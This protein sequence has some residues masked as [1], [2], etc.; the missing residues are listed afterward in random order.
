MIF[1]KKA[2]ILFGLVYWYSTFEYHNLRILPSYSWL[3]TGFT[4]FFSLFLIN[5]LGEILPEQGKKTLY[6]I[7]GIVVGTIAREIALAYSRDLAAQLG[8]EDLVLG[9]GTTTIGPY[10]VDI[11]TVLGVFVS[12]IM[13]IVWL[14][15]FFRGRSRHRPGFR[16]YYNIK[17]DKDVRPV[18][19]F[20]FWPLVYVVGAQFL[21]TTEY[22][23][24]FLIFFPLPF[25]IRFDSIRVTRFDKLM[26]FILTTLMASQAL[27]IVY[28][29][30]YHNLYS[31]HQ[32]VLLNLLFLI[33]YAV[34]S[35][36]TII[37]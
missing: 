29:G 27:G 7:I 16:M 4:I 36:A 12:F 28:E 35:I 21:Q 26:L 34:G 31:Y 24:I 17:N 33:P 19:Y 13:I 18:R 9:I 20:L 30:W 32:G 10:N 22:L 25:L 15:F 5:N 23:R 37:I 1:S 11:L 6:A 2:T 3:R 14:Q 8:H